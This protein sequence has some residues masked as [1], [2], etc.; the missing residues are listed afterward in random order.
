MKK[1]EEKPIEDQVE[2]TRDIGGELPPT[3]DDEG[4]I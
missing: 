2:N 1:E 3:D 4:G